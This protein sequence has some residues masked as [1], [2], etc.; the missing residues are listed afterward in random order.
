M[1]SKSEILAYV[2]LFLGVGLLVFTFFNAYLFLVGALE[3]PS[4]EDIDRLEQ[5][6]GVFAPLIE[7]CIRIMYL[8]IMGWIGSILTVR[9]IQF[10]TQLRQKE[11]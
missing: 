5:L 7:T 8:G 10:H 2:V 9:G 1:I 4:L 6:F 3:I 11:S